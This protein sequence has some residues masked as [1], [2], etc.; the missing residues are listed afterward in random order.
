VFR[1]F[2]ALLPYLKRHAGFYAAGLACLLLT[3][4]GQ[5]L[6]PQWLK[7]AVNHL[8]SAHP[9]Q[10]VIGGLVGLI[11]ATAAGVALARVGWRFF[12]T[13]A[14]RR[15]ERELRQ[16]LT[17]HLLTL[18]PSF[19]ARQTTGDLMARATN[20]LEAVRNSIGLALVAFTDA[21]FISGS[22]LVILFVQN[23]L[24]GLLIVSP[25]PVITVL[26]V[27]LGRL[28]GARF[29]AVQEQYSALS[30]FVQEHL[31]GNR[32]IKAFTQEAR[33][34]GRFLDANLRYREANMKLV[35]LWG[36]FF[37]V[38]TALAGISGL[39]LLYFGGRA[40][41]EH[42][43]T[44]GDFTAYLAYIGMLVWPLMGAGMVV[45]MLQRGATSL[46]RIDDIIKTE[47]EIRSPET[48]LPRPATFGLTLKDLSFSFSGEGPRALDGL[49]LDIP[50]GTFLGVLGRLGSGKT[51]L[52]HLLP[53]LYDPPPGTVLLGGRDIRD[54]DVTAL[55]RCFSMVPQSTF[56]FSDTIR[57]N[58]AF[59]NAEADDATLR[60][61][62]DLSTISRDIDT[63][64]LGWDTEVGE[65]G[66][67]LSGGQKQRLSLSRALAA[68]APIL[69]LD[70]ALSAVD[71]ETEEKIIRHL[72]ETR[73]GRTNILISHRVNT[74]KYCSLIIVLDEGR[75]VQKGTHEQLMA[76]Q[77]IYSET[78]V[79]QHVEAP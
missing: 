69:I 24:L 3:N 44:P 58:I 28:V 41:M 35:R 78:A 4:T 34:D 37:P 68:D 18:P 65:R 50:E 59:G 33:V 9:E 75:I 16:D 72:T 48:A 25:L 46:K 26:I 20:D 51:T 32:V 1:T 29:K 36:F 10:A 8:T 23:P 5:L 79:L 15:I 40:V 70:D 12:L 7:A 62:A 73:Q 43:L 22:I 13:G 2:A 76:E 71:V 38:I 14:S 61:M 45:N 54:Y 30:E 66:V 60:R 27:V 11:I 31:A 57:N 17:D 52:V 42:H 63:F 55:R 74:L 56:L 19:Y 49:S 53:R 6:I 39:I 47:P 64:T 21:V 67:T 77:G